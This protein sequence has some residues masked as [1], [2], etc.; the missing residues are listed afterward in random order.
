MPNSSCHSLLLWEP[1]AQWV[2][3]SEMD[4]VKIM[5]R[6]QNKPKPQTSLLKTPGFPSWFAI[7]G[8]RKVIYRLG[9]STQTKYLANCRPRMWF[10]V[11]I[12]KSCSPL[13]TTMKKSSW[14]VHRQFTHQTMESVFTFSLHKEK[15][16]WLNWIRDTPWAWD[17]QGWFF[18]VQHFQLSVHDFTAATRMV[19]VFL[20]KERSGFRPMCPFP[21]TEPWV[22]NCSCTARVTDLQSPES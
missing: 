6:R 8:Q 3:G 4:I 5:C 2:R 11:F 13:I 7:Q 9:M 12:S 1:L 22:V 19:S 15:S 20:D 16:S 10:Q 21:R 17:L 18:S 14:G